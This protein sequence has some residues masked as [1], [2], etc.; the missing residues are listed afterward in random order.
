MIV[1]PSFRTLH[2]PPSSQKIFLDRVLTV[3]LSTGHLKCATTLNFVF[4]HVQF[5]PNHGG[6]KM[7]YQFMII[8]D[9]SRGGT[10]KIINNNLLFFFQ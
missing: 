3:Q 7:M 9:A 10:D 6:E 5:H 4:V 2:R 8:M 1:F